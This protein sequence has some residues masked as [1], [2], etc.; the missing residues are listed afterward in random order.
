MTLGF[1][2]LVTSFGL[3]RERNWGAP[4][5]FSFGYLLS[6]YAILGTRSLSG[7]MIYAFAGLGLIFYVAS[8]RNLL[9]DQVQKSNPDPSEQSP[10]LGASGTDK[11]SEPTQD[12][13]RLRYSLELDKFMWEKEK[14]AKGNSII[15][16]NFGVIITAIVSCAAIV[17]S[18]LQV[19]I[20]SNNAQAQL[21]TD[22]IK[23]DRQ[24]YFE[25]AKF[26]L[27]HQQEI[28][29]REGEKILYLRNVVIS[30][31]PKDVGI[32]I[33]SRMRDTASTN[34]ARKVWED[35][36]KYLQYGIPPPSGGRS[37]AR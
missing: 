31:F 10:S 6:L 28:A 8:R 18:Y 29:A 3:V 32:Q 30:T 17:V 20:N 26:L 4:V 23:N 11:M 2:G 33:A 36:L 37:S 14:Y 21:D 22:R 9:M 19:T 15:N 13:D 7:L 34:E 35:G 27:D 1:F 5:A 16:R 25:I 12:V 24:F